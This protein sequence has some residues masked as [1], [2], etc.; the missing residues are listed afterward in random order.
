MCVQLNELMQEL[1]HVR[2]EKDALL[3]QQ[4]SAAEE[5]EK[6]LSAVACLTAERD[7]LTTD[8]QE[9]VEEVR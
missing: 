1:Q 4:R 8:L 7:Q 2:T 5:T 3:S 6:L 9:H